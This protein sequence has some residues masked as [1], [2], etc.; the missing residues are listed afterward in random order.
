MQVGEMQL[1]MNLVT[2][3]V[4]AQ[5]AADH[6]LHGMLGHHMKLHAVGIFAAVIAVRTLLDLKL[7]DA[8]WERVREGEHKI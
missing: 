4:L 6:R 3:D 1:Q 7:Q 5:W 2:Q 8:K